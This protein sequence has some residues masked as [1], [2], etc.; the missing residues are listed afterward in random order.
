MKV[1][2]F[3]ALNLTNIEEQPAGWDLTPEAAELCQRLAASIAQANGKQPK[4]N[5]DGCS[6]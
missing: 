1:E 4:L 3:G 2:K 5:P 6:S